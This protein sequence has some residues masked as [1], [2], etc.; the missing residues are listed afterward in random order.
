MSDL[1][2]IETEPPVGIFTP[3]KGAF[4]QQRFDSLNQ[5]L[6]NSEIGKKLN[7]ESS[8]RE[9]FDKSSKVVIY[10]SMG[11][12]DTILVGT[13]YAAALDK[14]NHL[15]PNEHPKQLEI[16][17]PFVETIEGLSD[18]YPWVKTTQI[19]ISPEAAAKNMQQQP[20]GTFVLTSFWLPQY[21]K[22]LND[23][24]NENITSLVDA[25]IFRLADHLKPW[26]SGQ[27]P[28][29]TYG[30]RVGRFM[31]MLLGERMFEDPNQIIAEVPVSEK[32]AQVQKDIKRSLVSLFGSD[33]IDIHS[34]ML[35]GSVQSKRFS[36]PQIQA[37]LTAMA[38]TCHKK[39]QD[40]SSNPNRVMFVTD[41]DFFKN[42]KTETLQMYEALS[43]QVKK[44]VKPFTGTLTEV[45]A[46][47]S[48]STSIISPD[49]GVGQLGSALGKKTLLLYTTAD[50]YLWNTGGD[51]VHFLASKDALDAHK[52]NTPT[53]LR[54]WDGVSK[55]MGVF[56]VGEIIDAWDKMLN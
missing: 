44:Y 14:F 20:D 10:P 18:K 34:L 25:S 23:N 33:S 19:E 32:M 17:S 8:L 41:P 3:E 38:E 49:T 30:A 27:Q 26:Q 22:A 24:R 21:V 52:E 12:G 50:P 40:G 2:S 1:R 13:S 16:V 35:S 47:E 51:N 4:T 6:D 15:H 5:R 37:L 54:T 39:D 11:V 48:L 42:E 31:E 9:Q 46:L 36:V 43:D 56:S 29:T 28:V 7:L 45:G 55:G 53:N